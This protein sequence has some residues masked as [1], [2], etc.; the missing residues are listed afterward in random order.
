[1]AAA[2][3]LV[4]KYEV[5]HVSDPT[6]ASTTVQIFGIAVSHDEMSAIG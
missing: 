5:L 6:P 3:A 2:D 1:M 4:D